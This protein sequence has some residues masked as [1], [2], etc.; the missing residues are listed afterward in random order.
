MTKI[1]AEVPDYLARQAHAVAEREKVP[2]DQIVAL[3]LSAQ[4]AAWRGSDDIQTRARR[5]NLANFDR[6]MAKVADVPPLPGDELPE[7]YERR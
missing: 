4:L 1:E 3:A 5:A 2:I 6:I 7:G